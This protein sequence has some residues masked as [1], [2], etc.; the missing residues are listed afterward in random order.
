M[1]P[2]P[3]RCRTSAVTGL[4]AWI[5]YS[6]DHAGRIARH[7]GMRAKCASAREGVQWQSSDGVSQCCASF[8]DRMCMRVNSPYA[9]R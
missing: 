1:L 3:G 8:Q 9:T 4:R 7:R 6:T 5:S 2:E